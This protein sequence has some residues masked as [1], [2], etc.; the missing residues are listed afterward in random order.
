MEN[1][2][3]SKEYCEIAKEKEKEG[4]YKEALEYYEKSIEEN[5][6]NVEAYFGWNLMN[7]YIEI[8]NGLKSTNNKNNVNEIN[9]HIELLSVFNDFLDKKQS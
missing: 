7:S 1:N 9:K 6:N 2:E 8:E 5:P 3:K 4:L